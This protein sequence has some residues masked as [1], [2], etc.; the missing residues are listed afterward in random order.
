ML[1][2]ANPGKRV[3]RDQVYR[4]RPAPDLVKIETI[5]IPPI[6]RTIA[7]EG[8]GI[9]EAAQLITKHLAFL[10]QTGDWA[11]REQARLEVE[12]DNLIAEELVNRWRTRISE[13]RYQAVLHELMERRISPHQAVVNLLNGYRTP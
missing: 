11:R 6:Q 8:I 13:D 7:L 1:D 3:S 9:S 12:L 2:M 5:W 4:N 10:H